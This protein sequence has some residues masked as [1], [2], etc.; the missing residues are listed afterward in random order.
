MEAV[1]LMRE[2]NDLLSGQEPGSA[3]CITATSGESCPAGGEWEIL[4]TVTTTTVLAKGDLMP[5]YYG[6]KVVWMLMR[7][8]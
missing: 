3:G 5:E 6:R 4:G 2:G 1:T 7:K 8:G